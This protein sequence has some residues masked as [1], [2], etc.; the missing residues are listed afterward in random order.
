MEDYNEFNYRG[1]NIQVNG[2]QDQRGAL[3]TLTTSV[4]DFTRQLHVSTART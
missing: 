1:T 2:G 4:T 3:A